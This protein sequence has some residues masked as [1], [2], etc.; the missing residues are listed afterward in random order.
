MEKNHDANKRQ[1]TEQICRSS[2]IAMFIAVLILIGQIS[3][4]VLKLIAAAHVSKELDNQSM[5]GYLTYIS[6]RPIPLLILNHLLLIG[7]TT[8]LIRILKDISK[9]GLPFTGINARR[10]TITGILTAALTLL[11][12]VYLLVQ[13]VFYSGFS[14]PE[15]FTQFFRPNNLNYVHL[16]FCFLLLFLSVVVRCGAVLQQESDETL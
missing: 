7:T 6:Y 15:V 14:N 11:S 13:E 1:T 8:L 16:S 4:F 3:T 9:S 10:L 2:R 12:P 5:L